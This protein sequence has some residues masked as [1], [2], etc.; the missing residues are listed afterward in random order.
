MEKNQIEIGTSYRIGDVDCVAKAYNKEKEVLL[1]KES[2]GGMTFVLGDFFVKDNEI[3]YKMAQNYAVK[4]FEFVGQIH[5]EM[6]N[7]V[8]ADDYPKANLIKDITNA[9]K[10]KY[11]KIPSYLLEVVAEWYCDKIHI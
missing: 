3:N 6:A 9:L 5:N 2:D 1:V 10:K 11:F 7:V 4:D 8:V